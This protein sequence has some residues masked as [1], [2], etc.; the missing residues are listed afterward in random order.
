MSAMKNLFINP[1][2]V[3]EHQGLKVINSVD[4]DPFWLYMA[5]DMAHG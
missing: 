1:K 2:D 4:E 3:C 5:L